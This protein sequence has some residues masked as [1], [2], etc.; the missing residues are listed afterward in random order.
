MMLSSQKEGTKGMFL[1]VDHPKKL[2]IILGPYA[3]AFMRDMSAVSIHTDE[4]DEPIESD[5]FMVN[6]MENGTQ[7]VVPYPPK[8]FDFL[9]ARKAKFNIED[10]PEFIGY[11]DGANW[12]GWA[13]PYFT[14]D[15]AEKVLEAYPGDEA[16][17]EDAYRNYS[18]PEEDSLIIVNPDNG[19]PIQVWPIGSGAW[20]W[21]EI[22]I[23]D[24]E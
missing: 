10:G 1:L 13:M 7:M 15:V 23:K 8:Y 6:L 3:Y 11:T 21:D 16:D 9:Y 18:F 14:R 24:G 19:K 2:P 20:C 5:I 12:N 4:K 22:A 17:D